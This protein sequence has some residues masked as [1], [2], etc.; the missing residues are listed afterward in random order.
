M[1]KISLG[2]NN[3]FLHRTEQRISPGGCAQNTMRIIQ[4]LCGGQNAPRIGIY[5]G[6]LGKDSR[7][8][9]LEK[10]VQAEKVITKYNTLIVIDVIR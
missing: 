9:T 2:Y 10:M 8:V 1:N 5:C 6:G 4:W 3:F 7:G